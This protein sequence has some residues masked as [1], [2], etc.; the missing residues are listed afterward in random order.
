MRRIFQ[1]KKKSNKTFRLSILQKQLLQILFPKS[2]FKIKN[3]KILITH[4][5]KLKCGI[6]FLQLSFKK[7]TVQGSKVLVAF[8]KR[9]L[10]Q[11]KR[12]LKKTFTKKKASQARP[13][14]FYKSSFKRHFTFTKKL[15]LFSLIENSLRNIPNRIEA[16]PRT[17]CIVS[18]LTS[19][20]QTKQG[21]PV[22]PTT[23]TPPP[24]VKIGGQSNP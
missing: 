11:A 9:L 18:D 24:V 4:E 16:S 13:C 2:F 15:N 8:F 6:N 22:F 5:K 23:T 12:A 17:F 14:F 10:S 21:F 7:V 3:I 19:K 20:A 1:K